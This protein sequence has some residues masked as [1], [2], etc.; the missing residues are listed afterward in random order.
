MFDPDFRIE[1]PKRYYRQ[2]LNNILHNELAIV[3]HRISSPEKPRDP[4]NPALQQHLRPQDNGSRHDSDSRSL[5][6]SI[7]SRI[8][9]VFHLKSDSS[10]Q[11]G[12]GARPGTQKSRQEESPDDSDSS[13]S[14]SLP[15]RTRTPMLDPST[16]IDP[17]SVPE[18]TGNSSTDGQ[19]AKKK[20]SPEDVSKHTFYIINSQMRLKLFARNEVCVYFHFNQ[21]FIDIIFF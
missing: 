6:G 21:S 16:N 5:L 19:V 4:E 2:G 3:E 7:K 15:P 12:S 20:K 13:S 17:M 11:E 8:S 1:R 14:I 10:H 9:R 18:H